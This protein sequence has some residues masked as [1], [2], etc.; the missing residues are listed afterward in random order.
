[1]TPSPSRQLLAVSK[2]PRNFTVTSKCCSSPLALLQITHQPAVSPP[3][4]AR[5]VW[6]VSKST[7]QLIRS[8]LTSSLRDLETLRSSSGRMAMQSCVQIQSKKPQN[9]KGWAARSTAHPALTTTDFRT[10][11]CVAFLPFGSWKRARVCKTPRQP[12][13]RSLLNAGGLRDQKRL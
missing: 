8:L 3:F 6:L 11:R 12:G 1:M 10:H 5:G 13:A 9:G 2:P 4:W 7:S